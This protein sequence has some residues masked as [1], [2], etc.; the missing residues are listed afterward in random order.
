[1]SATDTTELVVHEDGTTELEVYHDRF[2][3]SPAGWAVR[4]AV[5]AVLAF[6]VFLLPSGCCRA[7][8]SS[9]CARR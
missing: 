6:M 5:Y 8:T 4:I 7:A 3:P 1:M 2:R 9:H